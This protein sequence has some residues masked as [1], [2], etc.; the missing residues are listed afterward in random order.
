MLMIVGMAAG[1][2]R[3]GA[4]QNA[5]NISPVRRRL[6][7]RLRRIWGGRVTNLSIATTSCNKQGGLLRA[8]Y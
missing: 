1:Q 8:E 3:R 7:I 6:C 2:Q 5:P 4:T